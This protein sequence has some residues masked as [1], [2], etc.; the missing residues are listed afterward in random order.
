MARAQTPI[1]GEIW[2]VD[3]DPAVGAE[4]QKI[5]PAVVINVD[6]VGRLPLRIVVPVTDWKPQYAYFPWFVE[7]PASSTNGLIKDSGADAFQTKSLSESRFVRIL[8]VVTQVQLDEIASA[9]ALC[10]GV[11]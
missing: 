11:P 7:I 2:L 4:I 10:V 3:F 6:T 9:I 1:R 5:R 8:G